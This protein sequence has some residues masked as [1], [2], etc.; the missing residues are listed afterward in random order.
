MFISLVFSMLQRSITF[1]EFVYGQNV[2]DGLSSVLA[3]AL[4][5]S[6]VESVKIEMH[7][8]PFRLRRT[9]AFSHSLK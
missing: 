9:L 7:T 6:Q 1:L 8:N 3:H 2:M 4:F 5:V